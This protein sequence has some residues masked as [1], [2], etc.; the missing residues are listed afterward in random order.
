M[1]A[2]QYLR[3]VLYLTVSTNTFYKSYLQRLSR[4]TQ[5]NVEKTKGGLCFDCWV[6][7]VLT[8]VLFSSAPC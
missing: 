5:S 3:S 4:Q 8:T 1:K 7:Q 2:K 6:K